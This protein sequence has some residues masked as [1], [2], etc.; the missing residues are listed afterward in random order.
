M[1]QDMYIKNKIVEML[2]NDVLD[3]RYNINFLTFLFP[4]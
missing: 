4:S 3:V 1:K 2:D